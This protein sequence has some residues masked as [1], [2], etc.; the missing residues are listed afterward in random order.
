MAAVRQRIVVPFTGE[1][2]GQGFNSDTVERVG[3]GLIVGDMGEDP[4]APGQTTVFKFQM[5]TSQASFEK[6]LNI[7]A[8]LEARYGLFSGGAKFDFAESSAVA[9]SSSVE[10]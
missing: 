9:T 2:I 3:T 4:I 8:E 5:L 7:G 1:V 6:S 10:A